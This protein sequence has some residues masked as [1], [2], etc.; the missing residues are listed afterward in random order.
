MRLALTLTVLLLLAG[1]GGGEP[2]EPAPT[3]PEAVGADLAGRTLASDEVSLGDFRGKPLLVNV[4][5]S[6]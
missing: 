4:W 5:A 3:E 6:W 2:T 1:C